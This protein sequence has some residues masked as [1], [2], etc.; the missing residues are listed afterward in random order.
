MRFYNNLLGHDLNKNLNSYGHR[1][2]E[3][4]EINLHNY[5]LFVGDNVALDFNSPI[6]ETY[7]FLI[8]KRLGVDYYNL[9]IFNGGIDS[10][11]YNT[12]AWYYNYP[13]PK[14]IVI[15]TEFL[16]SITI[17]TKN[18]EDIKVADYNSPDIQQIMTRG[19]LSGF[20]SGRRLLAQRVLLTH[21]I[22]PIYQII[23]KD[24]TFL[25]DNG[26]THINYKGNIF[27]H[28]L[29]TDEF[30]KVYSHKTRSMMP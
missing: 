8:S 1:C 22:T 16:H 11:K 24:K 5:I 14:A 19:E 9:S 13:K 15:S 3:I 21:L 2:K 23:F 29:I 20:F 10:I 17:A 26:V 4:T 18:E 30:F 28:K 7:P 12:L 25:F 27:D 6:E